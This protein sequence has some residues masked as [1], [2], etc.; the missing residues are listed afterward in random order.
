[1]TPLRKRMLDEL[2]R[3]NYSPSTIRGY[4]LTF[5]QFRQYCGKSPTYAG[6]E[7]LRRFQ[8]HMLQKRKLA[9]GTVEV[10]M[11]ALRFL[12]KKVLRR[13]DLALDDM[14]VTKTPRRLP[15]ILSAAEV[16][17]LIESAVTPM[18]RTILMVLYGTGARRTEASMLKVTDIDSERMLVHIR[19]GKGRR[20]RDVPLNRSLLEALRHYWLLLRPAVYLFPSSAG[21]RGVKR[22]VSDKVVWYAVRRAAERAGLK[23]KVG[24][25]TLRHCFGTHLLES[26]TDLRTIQLWMGHSRLSDTT[27]YLQLSRRS[28]APACRCSGDKAMSRPRFE[29]AEVVRIAGNR[30]RNRYRKALAWPQVKVL[31]AT[32]CCRTQALAGHRK[33]CERCGHD[34]L[35]YHSCR[36]RHWPKCQ[37]QARNAW[38]EKRQQELLPVDYFHL[39]FSLPHQLVPLIWQNKRVLY[40]LLFHASAAALIQV[41]AERK[42]LGAETGF[43]S[44]LHTWGQTLERHPHI[45]CVVPAGGP[46]P[47]HDR[48]IHP[49]RSDFLV[50]VKKLSHVFRAKF[51]DGLAEAFGNQTLVFHGECLELAAEDRFEQFLDD[52]KDRNWVVY[53]KPPFGGPEHVLHYLARYT[54]RVAISNHRLV[55]VTSDGVTFRWKDYRHNQRPR[56][57]TLTPEEFLRRFLL[58]VLPKGFPRI[59]YFGWMANRKR[60]VML[61][62]CR[63]LLGQTRTEETDSLPPDSSPEPCPLCRGTMRIVE[64]FTALQLAVLASKPV[65]ILDST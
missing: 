1:M 30:F 52:L 28:V 50:P 36:N 37:T 47:D 59:R 23:Q 58:H 40:R 19:Q 22:P 42:Y 10:R 62:L 55:N 15:T 41:A 2:R 13:A 14:P 7:E 35:V 31:N 60:A 38:V 16:G 39:V 48:W 9:A 63:R 61:Q 33:R 32:T 29:V 54:H 24:P 65:P 43:L 46:S 5:E 53:A 6:A 57:M 8:L 45:H 44:I 21:H 12:Y 18:H 26:G 4:M 3:R 56:T 51:L 27:L 20:D 49:S 64:R 34:T 11:S 25:H 17:Q